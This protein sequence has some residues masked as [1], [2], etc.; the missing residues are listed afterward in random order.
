MI[1]TTQLQKLYRQGLAVE[2]KVDGGK[3]LGTLNFRLRVLPS[4]KKTALWEVLYYIDGKRKKYTMGRANVNNNKIG[5]TLKEA[6][7]YFREVIS[8]IIQQGKDLKKELESQNQQEEKIGRKKNLTYSEFFEKVYTPIEIESKKPETFRKEK[9][10]FRTWIE[11]AIGNRSLND[12]K[13]LDIELL[14]KEMKE[15]NKS[16]RTIQQCLGFIRHVYNFAILHEYFQGNNPCL[17]VKIPQPDN[18]KTKY[19][20]GDEIAL[21]V[22]KLNLTAPESADL[23]LFAVYTGSRFGET[24]NLE[25][26]DVDFK[27]NTITFRGATTK[28]AD[29]RVIPLLPELKEMLFRRKLE[30]ASNLIFPSRKNSIRKSPPVTIVRAMNKLGFNDS[31]RSNLEKR[32]YHS[33]R[34]TAASWMVQQGVDLYIVGQI[35]GHKN[36][37]TTKRYS[38]LSN[39]NLKNAMSKLSG[40]ITQE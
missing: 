19:F 3:G 39:E 16:D 36:L 32:T 11:P 29:T 5:L 7:D 37:K 24:A 21:L 31:I 14:K 20:T 12:V 18:Q 6:R 34:H 8:P 25:W 38:H 13:A 40:K 33:L 17:K 27:N 23:V 28:T 4:R 10:Y 30:S 2:K 9:S 15:K 26:S 1:N 22:E 35:L